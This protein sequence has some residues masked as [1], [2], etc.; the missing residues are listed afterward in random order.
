MTRLLVHGAPDTHRVWRRVVAELANDDVVAVDLPG[1][2]S[3]VPDGFVATKES[4]AEW[5]LQELEALATDGPVDVVG[6]DWGGLLAQRVASLRPDLVRTLACGGCPLDV[7]Y[8][9][10]DMA[11]LWQTPEVGEQV[12][13]AMT[14]E[15]LA[16]FLTTEIDADASSA[17]QLVDTTMKDCMLTLYRSSL[18]HS[19]EWQ[20]GV[21]AVGG[22]FPALVIWGERD[23][24]APP[25]FAERLARRLHAEL[26]VFDCGHWWPLEEP[27]ATAAALE[28]LWARG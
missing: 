10:H 8:E 12:M 17:A 23:V 9:W 27:T 25:R 7:E 6:H 26:V 4:Y 5:L 22:R 20:P 13:D 19:A 15:T 11:K 2:G 18:H 24:Y 21:E 1:F 16:A 14:P 28:R 3:P